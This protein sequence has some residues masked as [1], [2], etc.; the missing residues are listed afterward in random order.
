MNVK[1]KKILT[2]IV[3]IIGIVILF[4]IAIPSKNINKYYELNFFYDEN[5]LK[6]S[7]DESNLNEN[8]K[9][10]IKGL[11]KQKSNLSI[12]KVKTFSTTNNNENVEELIK[13]VETL[14]DGYEVKID[15]KV[16]Y[17]SDI[18]IFNDAI[19]ESIRSAFPNDNS[20]QEYIRSQ[21]IISVDVGNAV[22]S[23]FKI[24]N[25]IKIEEKLVPEN[26]IIKDTQKFKFIL[27]NNGQEPKY[28]QIEKGQTINEVLKI[29]DLTAEEFNL[30]NNVQSTDL[31]TEGEEVL[32]NKPD[33]M[34]HL[35]TFYQY[36]KLEDLPYQQTTENS[37]DLAK[38]EKK[39][40]QH[41]KNGKQLISY[42]KVFLNGAEVEENQIGIEIVEPSVP[43][44]TLIGQKEVS[45]KGTGNYRWPGSSC[46]ITNGY[47]GVDLAGYGGHRAIDIQSWYGAPIYAIDN[48]KVVFAGWDPYGGGNTVRID[49]GNGVVS[50]YNHM[51]NA[52]ALQVGQNVSKGQVIGNEG[53]TG[54]VTGPHLHFVIMQNG[55]RVNPLNYVHC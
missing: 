17:F 34:L 44:I 13:N 49:H 48:G 41:G 19:K 11:E 29:N 18:N 26:E 10:A 14:V 31:L 1:V 7:K 36:Q 2:I 27:N 54:L 15:D 40:K 5:Y 53:A 21:K 39:I 28:Y 12:D 38:G 30:N 22:F 50:Q 3:V 6:T 23:D 20:Y 51:M 46:R 55:N 35:K 9:Q 25:E 8:E 24:D 16:F 37:K 33:S 43:E 42:Q 4:L 52:P 47:G 32:V 45:G